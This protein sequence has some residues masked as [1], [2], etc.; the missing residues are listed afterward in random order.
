MQLERSGRVEPRSA[1]AD[2]GSDAAHAQAVAEGL[3][4]AKTRVAE[5]NEAHEWEARGEL[6]DPRAL[7]RPNAGKSLEEPAGLA[8][9]PAGMAPIVSHPAVC[10]DRWEAHLTI[11]L[12]DGTAQTWSPYSNP[13]S[14]RVRARSAPLAVPQGYITQVQA[15]AACTEAS[16]RLCS[17]AEWI[18]A[19][20]GSA[21][22][23][24]PYGSSE[25]LGTCNDHRSTHPASEYLETRSP[26]V[27]GKLQHPCI[28]QVADSLLPTGA[29]EKCV[30]PEG[31]FDMVGNVHEWT[32]AVAGTFR[33]G[34]YVDTRR[35]GEG[36][37]YVTS[38]H[39]KT[40]W[41][42]STGFRCCAAHPS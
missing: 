33:G 39:D 15:A 16:K 26:S 41:D 22:S 23:R 34:Y 30:T 38:A 8:G 37:D 11:A 14:V 7:V 25:E 9:C 31:V 3:E 5:G 18:A 2:A 19:C 4:R 27:F 29:K 12:A 35:N 24:F 20:R 40:Y 21:H 17:D 36:C 6:C 28:N 10:I 13:G 32:S 42:F 1:P